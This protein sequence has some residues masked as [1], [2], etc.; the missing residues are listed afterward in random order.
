MGDDSDSYSD[1]SGIEE[2]I[3]EVTISDM[4]VNHSDINL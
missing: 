4:G 2:N 1:D 3:E